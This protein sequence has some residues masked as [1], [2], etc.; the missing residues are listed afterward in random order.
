MR[1]DL[2]FFLFDRKEDLR[3]VHDVRHIESS[4]WVIELADSI[5]LTTYAPTAW[6][7]SRMLHEYG[8]HPPAPQYE[9][10][11]LGQLEKLAKVSHS[12]GIIEKIDREERERETRGEGAEDMEKEISVINAKD[13]GQGRGKTHTSVDVDKNGRSMV[14]VYIELEKNRQALEQEEESEDE[15]EEN[16]SGEDDGEGGGGGG[17]RKRQKASISPAPAPTTVPEP[18]PE[19]KVV[20]VT[21][22]GTIRAIEMSFGGDDSDSE[23]EEDVLQA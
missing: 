18:E 23:S 16:S 13:K 5:T 2:T 20:P 12:A 17:A 14:E 1:N 3:R 4:N 9:Q 19:P 6:A 10:M 21:T 11:R 7:P 15:D 22:Q 8:G